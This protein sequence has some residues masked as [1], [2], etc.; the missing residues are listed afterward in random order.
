MLSADLV[1]A[2]LDG[3]EGLH[4]VQG[5]DRVQGLTGFLDCVQTY[6]TFRA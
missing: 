3:L 2:V 6:L 1:H 5:L 4:D